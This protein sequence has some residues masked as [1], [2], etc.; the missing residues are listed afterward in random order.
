MGSFN[1]ATAGRV[2][3]ALVYTPARNE[4]TGGLYLFRAE[5]NG[6]ASWLYQSGYETGSKC[7]IGSTGHFS[8]YGLGYIAPSAFTDTA[9]RCAKNVIGFEAIAGLLSGR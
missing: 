2:S 4:H 3:L 7:L 9:N 1:A 5:Q 6:A 8:I